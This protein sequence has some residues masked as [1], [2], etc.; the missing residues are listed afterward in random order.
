M[1]KDFNCGVG[2]DVVGENDQEFKKILNQVAAETHVTLYKL[3]IC[4][5]GRTEENKIILSTP[6]GDFSY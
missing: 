1:F 6:Y 2:L 4:E 5:E 3:G